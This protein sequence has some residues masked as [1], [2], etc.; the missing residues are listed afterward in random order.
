MLRLNR[1]AQTTCPP[2]GRVGTLFVPTILLYL[3]LLPLAGAEQAAEPSHLAI[4]SL[5]LDG[6]QYH[7]RMVA[8]GERGHILYSD[9]R[10]HNW[11]QA[12][13]PTRVMLTGVFM[14]D[15]HSVWAV[16]HDATIL[17]SRDGGKSWLL[18]YRAPEEETPLLDVWFKDQNNGF[19][20][21]A[22]GLFL[23]T[24]DGGENWQQRWI[25]EVD[26]FHLNQIT[27][28]A[29][30]TLYIAA[31]SGVVYRSDDGGERWISL[32][33]PYHGSFF[34]S[35]PLTENRLFVFGLRGHLFSTEDKG[36]SWNSIAA[37]TTAM[38]TSAL[39]TDDNRCIFAGLSGVL[40]IDQGCNGKAL[41]LIQRPDRNGISALLTSD[42]DE[43]V[44]IGE[45][46]I[47]RFKPR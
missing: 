11:Q 33:T 18:N 38:L 25:S 8:V 20:V 17:K 26:D 34:G 5:L 4:H 31:E 16:G 45:A 40:L 43:L 36:D 41:Q 32:T 28:A 22:Y 42:N 15:E 13:V 1:W 46:G 39:K 19:A 44:L 10:G 23:E 14:I 47:T 35:L 12:S 6:A 21:G 2:Y 29:D 24:D 3:S 7:D 37:G 27:A 9:D 30:G